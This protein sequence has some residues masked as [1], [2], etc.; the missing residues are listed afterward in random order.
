[1]PRTVRSAS[2][3]NPCQGGGILSPRALARAC[4]RFWLV[5]ATAIASTG[6]VAVVLAVLPVG[7][8]GIEDVLQPPPVAKLAGHVAACAERAG[9]EAPQVLGDAAADVGGVGQLPGDEVLEVDLLLLELALLAVRQLGGNLEHHLVLPRVAL[10]QPLPGRAVALV[11]IARAMTYDFVGHGV[12]QAA[13]VRQDV[14][15]V[16]IAAKELP[17]ADLLPA[18]DAELVLLLPEEI[19]VLRGARRFDLRIEFLDGLCGVLAHLAAI[20][21]LESQLFALVERLLGLAPAP[22]GSSRAY[23]RR[24]TRTRAEWSL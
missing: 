21:V 16:R 23:A 10:L 14:V 11:V 5:S 20:G 7:L 24:G 17:H 18:V 8:G 9:S 1:M 3:R 2:S 15:H 22:R 13:P 4:N 6:V 19:A 12:V